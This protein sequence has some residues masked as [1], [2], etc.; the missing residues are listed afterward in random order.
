MQTQ[1]MSDPKFIFFFEYQ[2]GIMLFYKAFNPSLKLKT[3]Q[4]P[5]YISKK[6]K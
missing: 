3:S 5:V 1:L 2:H 6:E 4:H